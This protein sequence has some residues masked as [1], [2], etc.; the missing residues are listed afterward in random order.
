MPVAHLTEGLEL[1]SSVPG[2]AGFL[3]RATAGAV[4]EPAADLIPALWA[5]SPALGIK[6]R[7]PEQ[8]LL[9]LRQ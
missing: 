2:I 8:Q 1:P 5:L 3:L 7:L 9:A 6:Q 4:G